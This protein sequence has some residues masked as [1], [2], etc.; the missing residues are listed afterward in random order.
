MQDYSKLTVAKLKDELDR[1]SLPKTG[2]KAALVQRLEEDDA[3][4]VNTTSPQVDEVVDTQH[5]GDEANEAGVTGSPTNAPASIQED[6]DSKPEAMSNDAPID[7]VNAPS[8]VDTDDVADARHK[9][10]NG[11]GEGRPS[12]PKSEAPKPPAAVSEDV[13][14]GN[15]TQEATREG[16]VEAQ[17]LTPT[18]T[19]T[20]SFQ[21][22]I[23]T[24]AQTSVAP[25]DLA[26]DS[27]KRK[28]R[29]QSPPPSSIDTS[30]RLRH[31]FEADERP[32]VKLPEDI[33]PEGAPPAQSEARTNEPEEQSTQVTGSQDD[34]PAS[35]NPTDPAMGDKATEAPRL[36]RSRSATP[37]QPHQPEIQP[38]PT[39]SDRRFHS[40][41]ATSARK[42]S[43]SPPPPDL[44]EPPEREVPPSQHPATSALYIR[45]LMR[46]LNPNQLKSHL[47][48]LAHPPPS[49][50]P[51]S[52]PTDP[53]TTFHL[54]SIRSHALVRFTSVPSASRVRAQ[55]HDR[56]WPAERDRKPLWIDFVPEEKIDKWIEV[57]TSSG[58][59]GRGGGMKR[60]EVVY[61]SSRED[62]GGEVV[63]YMQE[64]GTHVV[65]KK[66]ALAPEEETALVGKEKKIGGED[67]K[68]VEQVTETKSKEFKALDDLFLSTA[69][70][71]PKLYY[72]PVDKSVVERRKEILGRPPGGKRGA[73]DGERRGGD[74]MRRFSFDGERIVDKGPE[75]GY[76]RG[77]GRGRGGGYRGRG[78]GGYRGDVWRGGS[79]RGRGW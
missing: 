29:S 16:S 47:S 51:P 38:K 26:E 14:A 61:E 72:L 58:S 33:E 43:P 67:G 74:E 52:S 40:L 8:E 56:V 23:P 78:G 46:P 17:L 36:S 31:E 69:S 28:R 63:A 53:I 48:T 68:V 35:T 6:L 49:S 54:D 3:E 34:V 27:R 50:S 20:D 25:E 57:Q 62:G 22:H 5:D 39:P 10:G 79:G 7:G 37:P 9:T 18:Q 30:K 55:L 2:L 77:G 15:V 4:S 12:P 19:Q 44:P 45:N 11:N 24:S 13:H 73:G 71:K 76:G 32:D 60:W 41:T 65:P 1:R 64:F 66:V 70:A 42:T 75:F 21:P 59:G